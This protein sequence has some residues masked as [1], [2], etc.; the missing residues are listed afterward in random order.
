VRLEQSHTHASVGKLIWRKK[1][2]REKREVKTENL[3]ELWSGSL[4]ASGTVVLLALTTGIVR[5]ISPFGVQFSVSKLS[6]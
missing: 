2:K 6:F 4:V 5:K 3:H 1:G